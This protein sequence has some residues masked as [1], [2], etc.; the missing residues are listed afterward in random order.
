MS[1]VHWRR[2]D[3]P[4]H[5]HAELTAT[6]TGYRLAGAAHFREE[7]ELV[8]ITYAV[9]LTRD[10]TTQSAA[11]RLMTNAGRRRIHIS[12]NHDRDWA[13]HGHSMPAVTG[14][15][16]LDLGFT[17][18]TNLI[19]IRRLSLAIGAS[20]EVTVAWF[21]FRKK[22]LEPLRQIYRRTSDREYAYES[23]DHSFSATLLV[24]DSGFVRRYPPLWEDV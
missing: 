1:S 12:V 24:D 16:D 7:A 17:P 18:A 6:E 10:W 21:D 2:L 9:S 3:L 19:S 15:T 11:L 22:T 13:V 14:C 20:A 8:A 23:P 4:G 5:D